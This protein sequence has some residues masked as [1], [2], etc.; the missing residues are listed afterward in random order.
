MFAG[1][2]EGC[3]YRFGEGRR[4]GSVLTAR[5]LPV[6]RSGG[7]RGGEGKTGDTTLS[8]PPMRSCLCWNLDPGRFCGF[9]VFF[10][11]GD[12]HAMDG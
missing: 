11:T 4:A 3:G 7:G 9:F 1:R 5:M 2:L 10:L 8:P 6:E 12:V